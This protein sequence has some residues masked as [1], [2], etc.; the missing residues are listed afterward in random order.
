[1][2][3]KHWVLH[4]SR[5]D[6]CYHRLYKI[7]KF[8]RKFLE[9]GTNACIS[10]QK[11]CEIQVRQPLLS[12]VSQGGLQS[13]RTTFH[14]ERLAFIS[15]YQHS[16][17]RQEQPAKCTK[18]K[19]RDLCRYMLH[20]YYHSLIMKILWVQGKKKNKNTETLSRVQ[21]SSGYT[22]QRVRS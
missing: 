15:I 1:M 22:R 2:N 7:K 16:N 8:I 9:L 5:L 6:N 3:H 20:N 12:H 10:T 21:I 18:C 14:P 17:L 11:G 19:K 13:N 4:R